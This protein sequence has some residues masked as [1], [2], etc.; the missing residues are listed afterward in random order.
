MNELYRINID[1]PQSIVVNRGSKHA[2]IVT[3]VLVFISLHL[4]ELKIC[5]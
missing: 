5:L 4:L 3:T 1:A 2:H